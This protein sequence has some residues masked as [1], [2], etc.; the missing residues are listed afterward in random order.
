M[1][2]G[3]H[4]TEDGLRLFGE[5][6]G[7]ATAM[8]YSNGWAMAF[9]TPYKLFKRYASHEGGIADPCIVSWP[10]QLS[11]HGAVRDHYA[12][13]SDVTP[14]VYDLLGIGDITT[15]NGIEQTPLEVRVSLAHCGIPFPAPVSTPS[16]T[17]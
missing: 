13:V 12:H 15:V 4:T 10:A 17:R 8:N 7:P 14:T 5:L 16:S 9:N 11:A 2:G 6:G 1:L 3:S